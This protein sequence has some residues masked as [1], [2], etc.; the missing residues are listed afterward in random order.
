MFTYPL[1]PS[2][3]ASFSVLYHLTSFENAEK[4]LNSLTIFGLDPDHQASFSAIIKR[5]DIAK[6]DEICLRFRW[7]G[8]QAM[9]FG[10]PFGRGEPGSAGL[11]KP[12]LYH[13]FSDDMLLPGESLRSKKY[14]QSNLYP[15][16]TGLLFDGIEKI[17][18]SLPEIPSEPSR[19]CFW[20]FKKEEQERQRITAS[21]L[22]IENLKAL[23]L[24]K[25]NCALL[26]P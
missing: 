11:S 14:W 25:K 19:L 13:I 18:R 15:G 9:Y 1:P 6:F 2:E 3:I 20:S 16:S 23:A 24:A 8:T 10:D 22:R 26:V 17:H 12:I 5:P 4:I 7:P 21:H